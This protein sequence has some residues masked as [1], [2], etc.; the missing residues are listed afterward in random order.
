MHVLHYADYDDQSGVDEWLEALEWAGPAVDAIQLDMPW[1]N[2]YAVQELREKLGVKIIIQVGHRAVELASNDPNEVA[3]RLLQYHL[4]SC[5]DYT[6][7]D[8]SGGKGIPMA[9]RD[10][11]SQIWVSIV[12]VPELNVAIA[13]GLGPKSMDLADLIVRDLSREGIPVSFDAQSKL[14]PSGD[15]TDPIDWTLAAEYL[16]RAAQLLRRY[17]SPSA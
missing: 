14:R 3:R 17:E 5:V 11:L 2:R 8:M 7:F 1:P 16:H 12:R 10:L 4:L 9:A 13:G 15:A 6:L